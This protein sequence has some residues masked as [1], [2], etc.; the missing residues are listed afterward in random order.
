MSNKARV[1]T[2]GHTFVPEAVYKQ[3][4]EALKDILRRRAYTIQRMHANRVN[5]AQNAVISGDEAR[6]FSELVT[7]TDAGDIIGYSELF[8]S[9]LERAEELTERAQARSSCPCEC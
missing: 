7:M 5:T 4:L 1:D 8:T 2:N 6:L 9:E 3:V